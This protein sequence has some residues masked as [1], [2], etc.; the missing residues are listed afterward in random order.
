MDRDGTGYEFGDSLAP[1][2]PQFTRY[3]VRSRTTRLPAYF[4]QKEK[5]VGAK[6]AL[7]NIF[8]MFEA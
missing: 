4:R 7:R 5:N 1:P 6:P 2:L 8:R 3:D